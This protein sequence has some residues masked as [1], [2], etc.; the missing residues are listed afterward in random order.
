MWRSRC[1]RLKVKRWR[2]RCIN[3]YAAAMDFFCDQQVP[4][5]ILRLG[6]Q[7]FF[8][9]LLESRVKV[10]GLTRKARVLGKLEFGFLHLGLE[11]FKA[12]IAKG[13][14]RRHDIRR[15]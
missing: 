15:D 13:D 12:F 4:K 7:R 6:S 11:K 1:R 5:R 9:L 2:Q 8:V 3:T 14:L 10:N